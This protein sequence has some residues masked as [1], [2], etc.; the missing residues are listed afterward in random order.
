MQAWSYFF[1]PASA[2]RSKLDVNGSNITDTVNSNHYRLFLCRL[3][4]KATDLLEKKKKNTSCVRRN[5]STFVKIYW[6][7][8]QIPCMCSLAWLILIEHKVT[9]ADNA[10]NMLLQKYDIF[11]TTILYIH[12]SW[13][14]SR[15]I[16]YIYITIFS[17]W[18]NV[19]HPPFC[20]WV[21]VLSH[22]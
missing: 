16:L 9:R 10:S 8:S 7:Q 12:S 11:I 13:R 2:Y 3:R 5:I 1:P 15:T 22:S 6:K 19:K 17:I 18:L 20:S 4:G 21:M 14:H